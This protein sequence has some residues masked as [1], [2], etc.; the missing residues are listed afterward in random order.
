[1]IRDNQD[2]NLLNYTI[3]KLS[4]LLIVGIILG[5]HLQ[6]PPG[7]LLFPGALLLALFI[8]SYKRTKNFL[9]QDVFF[10]I[11]TYILFIFIGITTT[12]I[13]Q[14]KNHPDH[15]THFSSEGTT[16][17]IIAEVHERLKPSAFQERYIL[18]TREINSKPVSGKLLLN[19]NKDSTL[20]VLHPG[21]L[22][23]VTSEIVQINKP[24][25]PYQ[26]DYSNYMEDLGVLRQV[27]VSKHQV[28]IL[29]ENNR[30]FREVAGN[31]RG[32]IVS[33]LEHYS[34]QPDELAI[35]QALLLGQRQEISQEIYSN[36]A[37]AGVIHILA[38]SGLHVGII[39]LLLNRILQPIERLPR[40]K[41]I[42]TI[43]LLLLLWCFAILA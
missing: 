29:P 42:K 14:P 26:F 17:F 20:V 15:F 25:N 33:N 27:N 35:I 10:G 16:E 4:L 28:M 8:I 39:L 43:I 22:L 6:I 12:S 11:T 13:H 23:A 5:N 7:C 30:G 36:Y 41:L 3:I 18:K 19:I 38:V 40:G 32:S 1:M 2:R 37:A 31:I 34:F 24:L 21:D 9:L